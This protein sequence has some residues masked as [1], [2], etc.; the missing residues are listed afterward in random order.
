MPI[1]QLSITLNNPAER[2]R[3]AREWRLADV[4]FHDCIAST[5][6]AARSLAEDDAPAWTLVIANE[7]T[8][9]RGQHGRSWFGE[10]GASLMFSLLVRPAVIEAA[11]RL[12]LRT[13]L[14]V[15]EGIDALLAA[16]ERAMLKWPN[17]IVMR[18]G[19]AGGILCESQ[20]RGD[21]ISVIVGIGINV[22]RFEFEPADRPELAPRFLAD[23]LRPGATRLNLLD[24]VIRRLRERLAETSRTLTPAERTAYDARDWL[25]D[26][27]LR[28]PL[29]GIAR[30]IDDHGHLLVE[31]ATGMLSRTIAGR[32]VL[33][34]REGKV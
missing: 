24:A 20:T 23:F 3:L 1:D 7:Q 31:D 15:A 11:A 5:Q 14:A 21:E 2:A 4:H 34:E 30:G 22:R 25:R 6:D 9:G 29:A 19:K 17:D 33:E 18:D 27:R 13:G 8:N 12:P 26:R 32:V 16:P 10:P 28:E